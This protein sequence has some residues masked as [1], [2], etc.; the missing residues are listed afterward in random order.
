MGALPRVDIKRRMAGD[1]DMVRARDCGAN[2]ISRERLFIRR[3]TGGV[4]STSRRIAT[5]HRVAAERGTLN[6]SV[7]IPLSSKAR[8]WGLTARTSLLVLPTIS[9]ARPDP[10][11]ERR[12]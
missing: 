9:I 3:E 11:F 10:E 5:R 12:T 7:G 2:R 1:A 4:L 8:L 6:Y